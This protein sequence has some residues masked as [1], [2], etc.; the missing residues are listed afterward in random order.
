MEYWEKIKAKRLKY[1]TGG[2]ADAPDGAPL[3]LSLFAFNKTQIKHI[4]LQKSQKIPQG[5]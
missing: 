5:A 1:L 2:Q 4:I 3:T